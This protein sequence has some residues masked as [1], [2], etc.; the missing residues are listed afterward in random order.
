M[1]TCS[2]AFEHAAHMY[3][4]LPKGSNVITYNVNVNVDMDVHKQQKGS[5]ARFKAER[6]ERLALTGGEG[7][8]QEHGRRDHGGGGA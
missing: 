2:Y 5:R 4:S 1:L 7:A 6:Q 8:E 3:A